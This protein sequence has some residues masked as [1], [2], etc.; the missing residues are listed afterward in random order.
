MSGFVFTGT[1][2]VVRTKQFDNVTKLTVV[3]KVE[4]EAGEERSRYLTVDMWGPL[5]TQCE[6]LEPGD[7]VKLTG[8]LCDTSY[9]KKDGTK[10]FTVKVTGRSLETASR[11]ASGAKKKPSAKSGDALPF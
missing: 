10:V 6:D 1:C 4:D 7:E 3:T 2:S 8:E 11:P 5:G 9:T